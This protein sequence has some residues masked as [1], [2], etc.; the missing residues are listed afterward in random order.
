M[1]K[2]RNTLTLPNGE[3]VT[4]IGK[5]AYEAARW[6]KSPD[7]EGAEPTIGVVSWH[8]TVAAAL[9]PAGQSGAQRAYFATFPQGWVAVEC[10]EVS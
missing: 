7:A 8:R 1:S 3:T 9:K 6:I 4:R 5:V 10:V 2:Y